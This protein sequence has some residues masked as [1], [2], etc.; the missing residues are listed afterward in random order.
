MNTITIKKTGKIITGYTPS[1]SELENFGGNIPWIK[2]EDLDQDLIV[3]KSKE[4]ISETGLKKSRLL[5]ENSILVSCIGN[6]GKMAITGTPLVSNQQINSVIPNEHFDYLFLYYAIKFA[7]QNKS[8][9]NIALVSILNAG[10]FGKIEIPFLD[11]KIKQHKFALAIQSKFE[12]VENMRQAALKQKEAAKALQFAVLREKFS[13]RAG[14]PLPAGWRW[15]KI[16][17]CITNDIDKFKKSS[18][19]S[20]EISYIDISSVDSF[21]KSVV[22]SKVIERENAPSRAKYI[23]REN[24]IVISNVRPN[25]NAVALI[26]KQHENSI[27]TSGFTVVRLKE[28][29]DPNYFFHF[30]TSPYFV[31][32][33]TELVQGAMYPAINDK[34]IKKCLIPVPNFEIQK[35]IAELITR[36]IKKIISMNQPL[37]T[38]IVAIE[39]LPAAILR[40]AF[41]F[42]RAE[43]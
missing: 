41:N 17:N 15:E 36:K 5:P 33:V 12:H 10:D 42:E 30:F 7:L 28:G 35:S 20:K 16:G 38:E 22:E 14:E 18:H 27:G 34:D 21:S 26:D 6:I 43:K 37:D 1:R 23:L 31:D 29:Y 40:E 3:K 9:F 8:D 13:W 32:Y 4:Y 19:S 39:A 11:D 2:P 25:L 24:D